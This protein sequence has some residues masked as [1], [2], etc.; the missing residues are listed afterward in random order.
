MD[1]RSTKYGISRL[2]SDEQQRN[3]NNEKWQDK[4]KDSLANYDPTRAHL[5]FEIAKGGIVKP[6]DKSKSI[7]QKMA[8]N[9]AAR[10]IKDPNARKDVRRRNR[11]I[12]Q[13]IFGGNRQRMHELAFGGQKVNLTKGADN[14]ALT[15]SKDIEHWARD[16]YDFMAR[17]Y[18]G[19][20]LSSITID[21]MSACKNNQSLMACAF[22]LETIK[23]ISTTPLVPWGKDGA[24][25]I[26]GNYANRE[27]PQQQ[28]LSIRRYS[29]VV[30]TSQGFWWLWCRGLQCK[31]LR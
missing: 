29:L 30:V 16:I 11:T 12:A 15:R 21:L 10:G 20:S 5:N 25:A 23:S 2:E 14:S 22:L 3:W 26:I 4:A 18:E 7:S 6:I 1:M 31:S 24:R 8:E 17:H 28:P 9:L 13:F 27:R 19:I